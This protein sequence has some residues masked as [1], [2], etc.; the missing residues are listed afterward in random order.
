MGPTVT[1][2]AA[3]RLAGREL[4][5]GWRVIKLIEPG[6]DATGGNFSCGYDVQSPEGK[7]A[8]LK[9]LDY[10]CAMR[11]P[12]PASALNAM[13]AAYIFEREL[14]TRCRDRRLNRI[15]TAIASGKVVVFDD[16]TGGVVE[17]LI[18]ERAD[19]DVRHQVALGDRFDIRMKVVSLHHVATGL[20]QLH[21]EHIAHQDLK[22]S[23]VLV[24][25]NESKIADLGRA[26]CDGFN[27]PHETYPIAGDPAYAPP[28]LLYGF[29]SPEW[30]IRRR[31][32]DAYLLGSMVVWFFTGMGSTALIASHL[33]AD[34]WPTNWK[35]TYEDV[36]P[37]VRNA[38]S[39]VLTT[40]RAEAP[41][42]LANDLTRI[43]SELCEPDPALRGHPR[44]RASKH[45]DQ[46]S[47]QRYVTEFDLWAQRILYDIRP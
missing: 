41:P 16:P 8:H 17:Y 22:P 5:D 40:F 44:N 43:V 29:V 14:L 6:P 47:L 35:G 38:F 34:L 36:L 1:I 3:K 42:I 30:N 37:F 24:F 39:K 10:S 25:D 7:M 9:A 28:E 26:S 11:S 27:P 19:G 21:G 45:L 32:C 33:Q 13:T 23:N 46:F 15:V 4:Q 18:F 12:D 20:S 2:S 31:G